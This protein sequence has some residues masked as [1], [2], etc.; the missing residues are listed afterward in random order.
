MALYV[1][2]NDRRNPVALEPYTTP[3]LRW[4]DTGGL[5]ASAHR[6][7]VV[8]S[9][10]PERAAAGVADVWASGEMPVPDGNQIPLEGVDMAPSRRYWAMV[11]FRDG[12]GVCARSEVVTFGTGAGKTWSAHPIWADDASDASEAGN[13]G[14]WALLRGAIVLPDVPVLWSTLNVTAASTEPARQFVYRLWL[15]G[16]QIGVGPVFPVGGESR[17]DGYDVTAAIASGRDHAIGVVAYTM[18]DRRFLAQVDVG[19]AD[20]TVRHY[21]TDASWRVL[22]AGSVYAPSASIGTQYYDAPAEDLDWGDFPQG[23][24]V[25]GYDDRCWGHARR[26]RPFIRLAAADADPMTVRPAA[27]SSVRLADDGSLIASFP[28]TVMGGVLLDM[29]AEEP[30]EVDVRCGE[31][32]EPDGSVRYRLSTGNVYED[33]WRFPRGASHAG[34][35][36]IRVFRHVQIVPVDAASRAAVQVLAAHPERLRALALEQPSPGMTGSFSCDVPV[37]NRVWGLCRD[38]VTALNA[39]IYVDSWTRERAPYE[40]DAWIQQRAHLALDYAPALGAYTVGWLLDHR[41]WPTEWPMYLIVAAHDMW[42][43]TGSTSRIAEWYDHLV[44]MLPERYRDADSGL[45]VKDPGA[46]S[47]MDGDLVDWPEAERD[48]FVFGRVNTVVNALASRA[49]ADMADLASALGRSDDAAR[50]SLAAE[51]MRRSIHERLYDAGIGAYRDGVMDGP[52]G[53]PI[54]HCGLHA[55]AFALAFA[56]V[57]VDRI[58]RL[59]AFL[60]AGGMRCSV[61]AAAVYL[62]GLYRAGLGA[63]ADRL[64]GASEGMRSWSNMLRQGAGAT[65]EAWDLSLKPNA[66]YSHPWAASPAYL[67]PEGLLGIRPVTAGFRRFAVIPQPGDVLWADGVLPV[68]SGDITVSWRKGADVVVDPDVTVDTGGAV[69]VPL[70]LSVD[71]P[72]CC[73]GTVVLMPDVL[74]MTSASC[75][76]DSCELGARGVEPRW[77]GKAARVADVWCPSGSLVL[78]GLGTGRHRIAVC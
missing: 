19:F 78:D 43:R 16:D 12:R 17:Y 54:D 18:K 33:H 3:V 50:L 28:H 56:D 24:S 48:G 57:P 20:G 34:H 51:R 4:R 9:T 31:V 76:G 52:D 1:T 45:I 29:Y 8:V 22:R 71:V 14:G 5:P 41:T 21:G 42:M 47:R 49:Y 53:R 63:D 32:L 60:R 37:L 65:M 68:N 64:I 59:G 27:P 35:W 25:S 74:G 46:S 69:P 75:K 38:T 70:T 62:D 30:V 7:E 77:L 6:W 61:Y 13:G 11:R 2:I 67:L 40:A 58:A 55:S 26:K 73:D 66:T 10:S 36:G 39:N 72:R 23:F 44:D 15:D